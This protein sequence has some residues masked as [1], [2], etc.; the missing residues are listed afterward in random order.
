MTALARVFASAVLVERKED[1]HLD[2]EV[3]MVPPGVIVPVVA[4]VVVVVAIEGGGGGVLEV[5]AGCEW[6][7]SSGC[8]SGCG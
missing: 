8:R 1:I 7:C 4:V 2:V 6:A 3:D 5:V